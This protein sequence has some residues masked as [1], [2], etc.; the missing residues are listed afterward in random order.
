MRLDDHFLDGCLCYLAGWTFCFPPCLLSAPVLLPWALKGL[1]LRG[2]APTSS[3]F[4]R[5]GLYFPVLDFAHPF[6]F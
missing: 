6:Q 5:F 4:L 2:S 3:C 1:P